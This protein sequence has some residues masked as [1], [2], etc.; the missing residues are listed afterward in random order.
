MQ[1]SSRQVLF[2]AKYAI[3]GPVGQFKE[4]ELPPMPSVADFPLYDRMMRL[5]KRIK[6]QAVKEGIDVEVRHSDL[7]DTEPLPG[8]FFARI[9]CFRPGLMVFTNEDAEQYR[10]MMEKAKQFCKVAFP[11]PRHEPTPEEINAMPSAAEMDAEDKLFGKEQDEWLRLMT[12]APLTLENVVNAKR[13]LTFSL[14]DGQ[15][16][17]K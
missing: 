8:G 10:T 6:R 15:P 1:V 13:K 2:G 3:R 4:G 5:S 7:M 12:I 9:L 16:L 17:K 11:A 14:L